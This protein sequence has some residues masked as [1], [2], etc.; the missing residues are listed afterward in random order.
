MKKFLII[1]TASIGDVI[2][3]TPVL[4]K[5][6]YH[7][8]ESK[9]DFLLKKGNESLFYGHPFLNR[10]FIWD[11][12]SNKYKRLFNLLKEIQTERYDYVIN[13]HRFGSSGFLTAFSRAKKTVGF[14]KN[15]FSIFFNH[16]FRHTIKKGN[17]HETE[18]NQKLVEHITDKSKWPVRLYPSKSDFAITSQ[19]KTKAYI[20]VSPASLWFTKQYPKEKWVSFIRKTDPDLYIYFLGSGKDTLLCDS[21]IDESKHKNSLNLAG[22][23]SFLESAALM[24][25]AQMNFVNDSAPMHLAS[26]MNAPTTAIFCSTVPAF[27]FGPLSDNSEIVQIDYEL[28]CRP[29]GLHGFKQC[30][31]N[32]FKCALT[33]DDNKLLKRLKT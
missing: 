5:L 10:L 19:Y 27:G 12:S 2:L 23:L 20:T 16:R 28:N 24:K 26:A 7:Y 4:E 14:N 3:A 15:P 21:I 1:Q 30:P 33:I 9:I 11:K 31:E 13:L 18:R 17:T 32:H 22:K 8:P 29:C 6:H 25:D